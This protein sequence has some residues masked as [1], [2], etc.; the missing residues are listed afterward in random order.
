MADNS[1]MR[2]SRSN[3]IKNNLDQAILWLNNLQFEAGYFI[4]V[5][6]LVDGPGSDIDAVLALGLKSGVGK[7]CYKVISTTKR[8]LVWGVFY[9]PN[10]LPDVSSLDHEEDFLYHDPGTDT[11][12]LINNKNNVRTFTEISDIPQT[13]INLADGT[14]WVSNEN[15]R[16]ARINDIAN[17]Y[18]RDE[19]DR[20]IEYARNNPKYVKFE[21]LTT[22]QKEQ[23]KGDKGEQGDKGEHGEQGLQGK[24]GIRGYNGTIENFVVLSQADYD[25][26]NYVDPYKFYFTYEDDEQPP[27]GEFYAYVLEHILYVQATYNNHCFEIN[28][29]YANYNSEHTIELIQSA[30]ITPTPMFDPIEGT[31][32]GVQTITISCPDEEA[33]IYYTLDGTMPN[34]SSSV[35]EHP[36]LLDQ[37]AVIKAKAYKQG[38]LESKVAEATYDLL[39]S[40]T[41]DDPNFN[42]DSGVYSKSFYVSINC[43]TSGATIR[44]TLDGTEPNENSPVYLSPILIKGYL[45]TVRA[46][47]FKGR[48]NES[49]PITRIYKIVSVVPVDNPTFIPV[50]G[51][52]NTSIDV[53]VTCSTIGAIIRY[54]LDGTIP[55]QDSLVYSDPI[56]ISET[57]TIKAKSYRSDME[58]SNV[59]TQTYIISSEPSPTPDDPI[60]NNNILEN[61]NASVVGTMLYFVD[62][63][64]PVQNNTLIL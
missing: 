7:N 35:Y 52:Y 46:K 28:S 9:D 59:V 51:T 23:L 41:V 60:V 24:R 39:F 20:R 27:I 29:A 57:T 1:I 16:V 43:S 37:S 38:L 11:W 54:T 25:A 47:A 17:Y 45:T 8:G 6:Y 31:Y 63:T 48:M 32:D 33:T 18:N 62:S 26:L 22:E 13:F 15:K 4:M 36:L 53:S 3:E 64:I 42:Y 19:I 56:T 40:T 2:I 58:P 44:Y 61:I 49:N 34:E 50:G 14:I 30:S 12:F 5:N 10:D 21:N 55:D